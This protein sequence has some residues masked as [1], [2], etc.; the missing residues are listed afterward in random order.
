MQ[1]TLAQIRRPRQ[2]R[3]QLFRQL[4]SRED[5]QPQKFQLS[6]LVSW[7]ALGVIIPIALA[8]GGWYFLHQKKSRLKDYFEQIDTTYS[9]FK[10]KG[11]RC[12]T[13]LVQLK[14]VIEHDLK[15]GKIEE[16]TY[17]LLNQRIER[18]LK[19]VRKEIQKEK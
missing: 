3:V 1:Y 17:Q 19:E 9:Q 12:E 6:S 11:E 8:I 5:Q 13:E 16:S 14:D 18:Y 7:E 2:E 15:H 4:L 10:L